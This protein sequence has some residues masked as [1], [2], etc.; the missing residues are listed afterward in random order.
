MAAPYP[1]LAFRVDAERR[2]VVL[3]GTIVLKDEGCGVETRVATR[4]EF[5]RDYPASE[6]TAYEVGGRFP[7]DIDRHF[8]QGGYC[9][10]WLPP[11]SPWDPRAPDALLTF[12]DQVAAFYDDQLLYEATGRWPRPEWAHGAAGYVEYL[13]ER[14]DG[15]E[16]VLDALAAGLRLGPNHPCPCGRGPKYKRCH[17]KAIADA[18]HRC[19][20]A[21]YTRALRYWRSR[22][23]V[24]AP[25]RSAGAQARPPFASAPA[26]DHPLGP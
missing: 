10:L 23:A 21:E 4:L 2:R 17:L 16:S 24:D 9:C 25:A 20:H 22:R 8:G 19:G 12:L 18:A 14:L 6:P 5:P 11:Q 1:G 15:E 13:L 26:G 3:E 7:R